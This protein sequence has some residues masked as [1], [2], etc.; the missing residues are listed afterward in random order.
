[1]GTD[2]LQEAGVTSL[3]EFS[4]RIVDWGEGTFGRCI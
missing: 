4:E 3:G 1:M 2:V